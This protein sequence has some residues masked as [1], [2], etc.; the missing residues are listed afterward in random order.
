M[1][2]VR[3]MRSDDWPAVRAIYEDGIHE[4]NATFEAA[5]PDRDGVWRDACMLERR[6][7]AVGA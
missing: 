3:D 2:G 7:P 5:A 1:I 4:G 6:S